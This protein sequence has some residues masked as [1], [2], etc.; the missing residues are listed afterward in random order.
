MF[1]IN[2]WLNFIKADTIN[3]R[4]EL[5]NIFPYQSVWLCARNKIEINWKFNLYLQIQ[6]LVGCLVGNR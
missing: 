5:N 2:L 1:I 6:N 4:L 3:I